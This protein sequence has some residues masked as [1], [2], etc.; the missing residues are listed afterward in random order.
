MMPIRLMQ[1]VAPLSISSFGKVKMMAAAP[2]T[3]FRKPGVGLRLSALANNWVVRLR[4]G[5]AHRVFLGLRVRQINQ[6]GRG[7]ADAKAVD[8]VLELA[9]E[10]IAA[11]GARRGCARYD[12][13]RRGQSKRGGEHD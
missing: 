2:A 10:I 3:R 12:E 4:L 9:C 11:V 13:C 1:R 8:L 5:A 7:L 6:I